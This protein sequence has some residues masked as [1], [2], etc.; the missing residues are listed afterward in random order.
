MAQDAVIDASIDKSALVRLLSRCK[1]QMSAVMTLLSDPGRIIVVKGSKPLEIL[2]NKKYDV[3]LYASEL[4]FM[5]EV[6]MR[7]GGW[8]EVSVKP[9]SAVT[10]ECKDLGV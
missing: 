3:L 6:L 5:A 7:D 9:M 8:S 10:F 4:D 2:Y 1:G